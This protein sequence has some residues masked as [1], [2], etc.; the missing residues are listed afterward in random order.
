MRQLLHAIGTLYTCD[1]DDRTL[2]D[3]YLVIENGR[4][5]EIGVGKPAGDFD[6]VE[7]MAGRLVLPGFVNLHHHYFQTLTRAIPA[8]QRGHLIDWLY[9]MYPLWAAMSPDDL[10]SATEASVA[11]LLLTGATTSVDHSYLLPRGGTEHVEAEIAAARAMGA[12][13]VFVRGSLTSLE[14]D[15]EARLTPM[16]GERAGG[17][18]D[19]PGA[20]LSDMRR[21]IVRFHEPSAGS[22]VTVALGPTTTTYDD[23]NFMRSVA[24]LAAET[25]TRLH[26]HCHPRPD[27]RALCAKRGTTPFDV[28]D[29]AGWLTPRTFFAHSTRMYPDEMK[30]CADAGVAVA[31]CP[32]MIMRLG[33][34]VTPIHDM[35]AAGIRI[36]V[37]VD[38]GASNDSGSMLGEMRLALLL[39]RLAGGE[40][41]VPWQQWFSPYRLLQMATRDAAS[42]IGRNDIGRI[43]AGLCA[44][45]AAFD[46][47][48]VA[49][50]GARTDALSALL[51]AGDDD[52]ASFVMVGGEILVRDRKLTRADEHRIGGRVD[53]S[54]QKLIAKASA[55]S[56]VNYAAFL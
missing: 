48:S 41:S 20:V 13:L 34:R 35:L 37:G 5:A 15:L 14:D 54:T 16:L 45:L 17:L 44:D 1:G 53:A 21:T 38:G 40:G 25:E 7:D 6:V 43:E 4:I 52:R 18:V 23:L 2:K 47:S 12:R 8:A 31:H 39:H 56:R 30:R 27:E 51:L 22:M 50:A 46:L 29:N 49:Y 36:G 33:A 10:A 11:Q 55:A 19:D 3:A 24:D 9:K 42:I 32:R 28:L 26:I